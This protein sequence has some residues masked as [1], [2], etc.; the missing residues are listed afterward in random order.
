MEV[1]AAVLHEARTPLTVE[2]VTL[3]PPRVGEVLVR[4]A[5]A[6]VCHSDVRLADGDLGDG[7]WPTVLG[8]EGAGVVEAVGPDTGGVAAG[9]RVAFCFV[10]PCRACGACAAGRFN[11]CET[12]GEHAWAGTLLDGTTRLRLADGRPLRHFNFVSCFA[13]RCVVPAASAVP[14]PLELPLWQAALLGCAVVTGFGAVRNAARVG[15]GESVC[16]VGC[17]GIGQQIVAAARMA[18]AGR[19][20][21][22]DRDA[23]KLALARRR[24][25]TDT[26]DASTGDPARAVL[27]LGPGGV[28]HALEA[29]GDPATIR[30]AWDVLRPGAAAIVV[31][32]APRGAE[33]RVPALELLSEKSL[34]G[35]YYG[36]GNPPLEIA[37][38]GRLMADGRVG[39]ADV[40]S[41]L[42]DLEGIEAA[43]ER[44]RCGSGDRS[45]A[46]IDAAL[47]GAPD[48]ALGGAESAV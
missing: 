3:D 16:V 17:G 33:A 26:V 9:D 35:S 41:H 45:V 32:I 24:G 14:I 12:A 40:V 25:A 31:G 6:G 18:G 22:V 7:R 8:H 23:A 46:V 43:F 42:T 39:V 37:R 15:I 4:V 34:R 29:V 2:T 20:V 13:E 30:L 38:L 44:L 11:L 21:A 47:A 28:D 36:S 48:Q 1:R 5:A 19:I 10:P 27:A